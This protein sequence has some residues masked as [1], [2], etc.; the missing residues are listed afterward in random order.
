MTEVTVCV[1]QSVGEW[2]EGEIH[3]VDRTQFVDQMIRDGRVV[4]LE[5]THCQ[6]PAPAEEPLQVTVTRWLQGDPP[7]VQVDDTQPMPI[8]VL[9][10]DA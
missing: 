7:P 9:D 5:E 10:D 4:V 6:P 1:Y 8:M 3:T 2:R